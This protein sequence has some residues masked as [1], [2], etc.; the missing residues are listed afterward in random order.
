MLRASYKS[1]HPN[2]DW[3]DKQPMN[4]DND[5]FKFSKIFYFPENMESTNKKENNNPWGVMNLEEFLFY[6]CPECNVK[7]KSRDEFVK[8]ALNHHPD[9]KDQFSNLIFKL[10]PSED[11]NDNIYDE[12][13][14]ATNHTVSQNL[15]TKI[16]FMDKVPALNILPTYL[17]LGV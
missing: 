17:L 2:G 7:D 4:F 11:F 14:I 10:D 6:C 13:G 15:K 5:K 16:F 3:R 9:A 12:G 1:K 8:H